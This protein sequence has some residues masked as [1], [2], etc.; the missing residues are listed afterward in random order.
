M[1]L[2]ERDLDAHIAWKSAPTCTGNC[3]QGRACDCV[4]DVE[5]TPEQITYLRLIAWVGSPVVAVGVIALAALY[6]S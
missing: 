3:N 6:L 4:A 1:Q 2:T 5:L